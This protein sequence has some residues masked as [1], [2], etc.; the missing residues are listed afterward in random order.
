M[1]PKFNLGTC[2]IAGIEPYR[3]ECADE[4]SCY[5]DTFETCRLYLLEELLKCRES[6]PVVA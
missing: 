1:C 5:G 3:V 6:I 2:K 4:N